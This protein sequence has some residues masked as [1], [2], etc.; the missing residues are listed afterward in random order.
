VAVLEGKGS[1]RQTTRN[2]SG[3]KVAELYVER[4]GSRSIVG[5]I[6]ME[7]LLRQKME[8]ALYTHLRPLVPTIFVLQNNT[9]YHR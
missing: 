1:A 6:Y 4:K 7:I 2:G 5:N 8:Q 9:A 3:L